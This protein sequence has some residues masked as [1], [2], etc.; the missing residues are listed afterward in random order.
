MVS[1]GEHQGIQ[2]RVACIMI[3]S[4]LGELYRAV[5]VG[6]MISRKRTQ[7]SRRMYGVRR[8]L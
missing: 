3:D 5:Q 2:V 8:H 7:T 6:A 1:R 4:L